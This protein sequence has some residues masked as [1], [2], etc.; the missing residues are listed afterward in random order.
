M[1][2]IIDKFIENYP[3]YIWR[4]DANSDNRIFGAENISID[5]KKKLKN[6]INYSH[7]IG[8]KYIKQKIESFYGYG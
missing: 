2:K 1:I 5:T 3:N 8:E 6:F 7:E 4:D